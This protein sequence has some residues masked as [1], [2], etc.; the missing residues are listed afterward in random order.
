MPSCMAS[1]QFDAMLYF[2]ER[3]DFASPRPRPIHEI[4]P[5]SYDTREAGRRLPHSA[6][7]CHGHDA[8]AESLPTG[9]V[10]HA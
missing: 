7:E 6:R 1:F 2:R 5:H 3:T 4:R 10:L 9:D 8:H